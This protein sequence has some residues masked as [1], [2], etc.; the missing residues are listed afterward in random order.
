MGKPIIVVGSSNVDL[1]MKMSRLPQRGESVMDAVF[2][3]T[4]GGKG[5]NQAVAAAKAGALV[6][7][8][9][10]VGDD[11]YG[12]QMI[13]NMSAAGVNTAYMFTEPNIA[14]GTALIMVGS[15][16]ENYL[17]VAPGANGRLQPALVDRAQHLFLD[18]GMLLVQYEIPLETLKHAIDQAHRAGCPVMFN[19]AP[20]RPFPEEAF[21]GLDYLVVNETEA[22]FLTD[23]PVSNVDQA[24]QAAEA[25][26]GKGP[27]WV[28]L[29]LGS[30]GSIVAGT[31]ERLQVP[32]YRVEAVD[33]T[34]AGDVFCGALAAALVEGQALLE[35]LQFASAAAA[36][37]VTRMGAQP[38][39]PGR[40]EIEALIRK[41][42]VG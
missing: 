21:N 24:W 22:A 18:A 8:V 32:A 29:T 40:A 37:A 19:L 38:S 12:S 3:Q 4:F 6:Y 20:P 1:V 30:G 39:I 42:K 35:S 33:T 15:A 36:I 23:L 10:C 11:S 7:F 9:N 5:A 41:M 27:R 2:I 26:L 25:L 16:G 28:I 34:A 31:G 14:T 13:A 17:G